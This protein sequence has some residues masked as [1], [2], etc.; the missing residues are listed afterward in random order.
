M[1]EQEEQPSRKQE[2]AIPKQSPRKMPSQTAAEAEIGGT[3]KHLRQQPLTY[4]A[5]GDFVPLGTRYWRTSVL[6]LVEKLSIGSQKLVLW[7]RLSLR[8]HCRLESK[9]AMGKESSLLQFHKPLRG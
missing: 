3:A 2:D 4:T 5:D 9:N 8:W 6:W 7:K 1:G